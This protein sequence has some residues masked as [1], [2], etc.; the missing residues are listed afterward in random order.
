MLELEF[1]AGDLLCPHCQE[2]VH[3]VLLSAAE[4]AEILHVSART[5]EDW[6]TTGKGPL[7]LRLGRRP[8]YRLSDIST[9]LGSARGWRSTSE[10]SAKRVEAQ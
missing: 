10:E 7:Y 4:A 6:R 8:H 2:R 3:D 9:W 1:A 5:L